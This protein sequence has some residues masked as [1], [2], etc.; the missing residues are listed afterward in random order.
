MRIDLARR[1]SNFESLFIEIPN[2]L[3]GICITLLAN[4]LMLSL[5]IYKSIR[6]WLYD[7]MKKY[8]CYIMDDFN[9]DICK[10][11]KSQN[12]K[13]DAFIYVF[14][15]VCYISHSPTYMFPIRIIFVNTDIHIRSGILIS[16]TSEHLPV[17]L[18][19]NFGKIIDIKTKKK[20][21]KYFNFVLYM[22][23]QTNKPNRIG[24]VGC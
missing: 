1:Y 4:R 21:I 18:V 22:I 3:I 8:E 19:N 16:D 15:D 14:I 11:K 7:C 5:T 20:K 24:F 6:W 17:F 23:K 10:K 13:L 9:L 2:K 12:T